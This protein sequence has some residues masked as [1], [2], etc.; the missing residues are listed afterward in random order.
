MLRTST[1]FMFVI[2]LQFSASDSFAQSAPNPINLSPH[3]RKITRSQVFQVTAELKRQEKFLRD[4]ASR[5]EAVCSYEFA[6]LLNY[7]YV[8]NALR[9]NRVRLNGAQRNLTGTQT[10]LI[11]EGYDQLEADVLLLF[12]DHQ[13]SLLND[14]LELNELQYLEMQKALTV[15]LDQKRA[16]VAKKGINPRLFLNRLDTLSRQAEKKILSILFPEQKKIFHKQMDFTKDR[17]VG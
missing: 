13:M 14:A 8:W 12:L 7:K 15:D 5:Y 16:L 9:E 10:K 3:H 11:T 4:V 6:P 2:A 17:L 1:L